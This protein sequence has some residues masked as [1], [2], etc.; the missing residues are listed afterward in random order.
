MLFLYRRPSLDM[1]NLCS[2]LSGGDRENHSSKGVHSMLDVIFVAVTLALF[3]LMAAYAVGC[4][5]L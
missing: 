1:E 2:F 3:G 4:N 5:K